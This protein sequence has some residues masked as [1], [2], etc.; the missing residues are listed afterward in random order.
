M[1]RGQESFVAWLRKQESGGITCPFTRPTGTLIAVSPE[2][3]KVSRAELDRMVN[4]PGNTEPDRGDLDDPKIKW[5]NG[6]PN[7]TLANLA[8]LKGKS[9]FHDKGSLE[10]IVENAVKTWE[11]E[12]SHKK[13]TEQWKTIVHD[14]YHVQTNGG[15]AFKLEEAARRGNYNILM[16]HVDKNL[17]DA[18]T[19]DF[20]SSHEAFQSAFRSS[21]PW[22][23]LEVY[24]GPPE[25]VFK[26]RHWGEFTGDYNGNKGEEQLVDMT[27][28]A[29][30]SVTSALKI[31][32]IKVFFHPE[33][34]LRSLR[35]E[36]EPTESGIME[37]FERIQ[38]F[39]KSLEMKEEVKCDIEVNG[40]K[41]DNPENLLSQYIPMTITEVFSSGD[42][43]AFTWSSS[44]GHGFS[45]ASLDDDLNFKSF[46]VFFKP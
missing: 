13:D 3:A 8:Y 21:F 19:E 35:G 43:T 37:N 7:Y 28:F 38:R 39:L 45:I 17:Y 2:L 40:S 1:D 31:T 11:M 29:S 16:D 22:E 6:K 20:E 4:L 23:V 34:F 15:K 46:K 10:M 14:E 33:K 32:S 24:A 27:G 36:P 12:A 44:G 41:M 25:I 18:S 30:V 42:Q 26:W 5:R 9:Q